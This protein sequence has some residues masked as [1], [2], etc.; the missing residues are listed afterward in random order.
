MNTDDKL[1]HGRTALVTGA[2]KGIGRGIAEHLA[3]LGVSLVVSS[4]DEAGITATAH[5]IAAR[6]GVTVVPAAAD[7]ADPAA[8]SSLVAK[9]IESFGSL[10]ILIN[11]SGGPPSGRFLDLDDDAWQSAFNLLLLGVVRL[12]RAAYPYLRDSGHGRIIT[13]ASTSV[14]QPIEGL[15]L[16]NALRSGVVGLSKTLA[17]EFGPDGVTVNVVAPGNILTDRLRERSAASGVP[18]EDALRAAEKNIPLG[19]IGMPDD[20][21]ALVAFLCTDA[22]AYITGTLIPVDG[23]LTRGV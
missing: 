4:R 5:E 2:S 7:V 22:A 13:V 1:L 15:I 23:G 16:S 10:D 8:A 20:M 3:S 9:A 19:R 21:G 14:K 17:S 6:H 11:N 18:I 12:I